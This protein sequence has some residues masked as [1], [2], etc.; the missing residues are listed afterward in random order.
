MPRQFVPLGSSSFRLSAIATCLICSSA[1][2]TPALK[3]AVSRL[4]LAGQT[5]DVAL[6]LTGGSGIE[7]PDVVQGT[8]I[9]LTFTE[10]LVSANVSVTAGKA[11]LSTPAIVRGNTV[12]VSLSEIANAQSVTLG[13]TNIAGVAGAA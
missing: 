3:S 9:V 13:V 4:S 7:C 11:T 10:P 5:F 1:L 6:P 2:A 12:I 8:N